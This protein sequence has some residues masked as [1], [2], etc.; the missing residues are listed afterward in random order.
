MYRESRGKLSG[1]RSPGVPFV[2]YAALFVLLSPP[3]VAH[4][5]DVSPSPLPAQLQ[6]ILFPDDGTPDVLS[7]ADS[8]NV[9]VV[10]RCSF[11][12]VYEVETTPTGTYVYASSGHH[13]LVIDITDPACPV[14]RSMIPT[15]HTIHGIHHHE[16]MLYLALGEGGVGVYDITDPLHPELIGNYSSGG[17]IQSVVTVGDTAYVADW[18]KGLILLSVED[19][20]NPLYLGGTDVIDMA[21]SITVIDSFIYVTNGDL[22]V[23]QVSSLP[24]SFIV[25]TIETPG[26]TLESVAGDSILV[27]ADG[28]EGLGVY[29]LEDPA[30]PVALSYVDTPSYASAVK[31]YGAFA[32]VADFEAGLRIISVEDPY[33][34]LEVGFSDTPGYARGVAITGSLAVIADDEEGMRLI[35]LTDPVDPAFLGRFS[36][37]LRTKDVE[38]SGDFAYIA[39]GPNG[40][41][42]VSIADPVFP[43]H[44]GSCILPGNAEQIAVADSFAFVLDGDETVH[45][46][47]ISDPENPTVV[48]QVTPVLW[49]TINDIDAQGAYFYLSAGSDGFRIYSI[50]DPEHPVEVGY[51]K[52]TGW[53]TFSTGISVRG[54][55]ACV[56]GEDYDFRTLTIEDPTDPRSI[57]VIYTQT[58][59]EEKI[60]IHGT[61][62]CVTGMFFGNP[63]GI[64][65]I[66]I[67]D[68]THPVGVGTYYAP[69][70]G[71]RY[72]AMNGTHAFTTDNDTRMTVFSIEEPAETRPVGYYDTGTGALQ[73]DADESYAYLAADHGGLLILEY[74]QITSIEE[75]EPRSGSLPRSFILSQNYPNPF[76]P[77]TTISFNIPGEIG[78]KQPVILA[79]YDLRG[80][81][82]KTLINTE[83]EPGSHKVVWDGRNE[84]GQRV[85]SG[86][87]LYN[88]K[89]GDQIYT[90]KMLVLE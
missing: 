34:P 32:C 3:T 44:I 17:Y 66:S 89:S 6:H 15:D 2:L 33:N 35:E 85:S 13:L 4:G 53:N 42:V 18:Y 48:S 75:G 26:W 29:S 50:E 49:G 14:R 38:I 54:N 41:K 30:V 88:L 87:Y 23:V 59:F 36:A 74:V 57:S 28:L 63:H 82:V 62:A 64:W 46:I 19:P 78:E 65:V 37:P 22:N 60:D 1:R 39:D 70:L 84:Q 47:S 90:R 51:Y 16:G 52:L 10:G 55:L 71:T 83:L 73:L 67:A 79:I 69:E 45:V 76:N 72:I 61:L 9:R 27:V 21:T 8:S 68:S 86:A 24:D 56:V 81:L 12:T 40:M 43:V 80:R 31:L 77:T 58:I 25:T 11:G 7:Q 5:T 20:G